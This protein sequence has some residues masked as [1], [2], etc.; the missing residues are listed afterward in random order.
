MHSV[1]TC[2]VPPPPDRRAALRARHRAAILDAARDL[3]EEAG[4]DALSADALARRADVARR[5]L[6][7]HF[8]SLEEV[9]VTC[10]EAELDRAIVAV[11]RAADA[12]GDVAGP[13]EDL[14][15]SLRGADLVTAVVR[16][17][18]MTRG[19]GG[20]DH[21]QRLQQQAMNHVAGPL[22]R[23]LRSRHPGLDEFDAVL[24]TTTV[25]N[26][27][28]LVAAAWV[29]QTD[30]RSDEA[31]RRRWDELLDHLFTALRGG[32][33]PARTAPP[34]TTPPTTSSPTEGP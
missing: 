19:P 16:I 1:H 8:S 10:L 12:T 21:Q 31:G 22:A 4:V 5:T 32:F 3:I 28:S 26:G 11:D 33:T 6:F 17:A 25:M 30:G 9:V 34:R 27:V 13:L 20:E 29:Q 24:L 23:R 2:P 15:T 7:N 18:R 14:E